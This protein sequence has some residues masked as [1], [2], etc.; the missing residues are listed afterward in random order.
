[1]PG[2]LNLYAYCNNNPI[3]YTDASGNFAISLTFLGFIIGAVWGAATGG[4]T[5]I[6]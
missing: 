3:M 4:I 1:M 6:I 5:A 2:Q